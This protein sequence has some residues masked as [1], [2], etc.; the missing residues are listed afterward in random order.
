MDALDDSSDSNSSENE[1]LNEEGN[2]LTLIE[3]FEDPQCF[4]ED[5]FDLDPKRRDLWRKAI[6][7]ELDSMKEK[8]VWVEINKNKIPCGRKLIGKRW[9]SKK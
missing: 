2:F 4:N 9:Y 8:E 3:H 1:K 7:K 5:H 6:S